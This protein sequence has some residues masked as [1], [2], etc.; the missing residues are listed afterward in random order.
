MP[1]ARKPR[2]KAARCPA[3]AESAGRA[4]ALVEANDCFYP[5]SFRTQYSSRVVSL[6][7]V[8]KDIISQQSAASSHQMIEPQRI[9]RSQRKQKIQ[10]PAF[11]CVRDRSFL[12][13]C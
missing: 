10:I 2:Q 12:A 5:V 7:G 6:G 8:L 4:A 1:V 9:Q 11:V 13:D 3:P